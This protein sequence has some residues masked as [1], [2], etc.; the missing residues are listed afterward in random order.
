M[1]P[2]LVWELGY[3]LNGWDLILRRNKNFFLLATAFR[4]ALGST[5]RPIQWISG[6]KA[7]RTHIWLSL[8]PC[9]KIKNA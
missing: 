5:Q 2:L 3:E 7:T 1:Y 9:A 6:D 8:P 4:T